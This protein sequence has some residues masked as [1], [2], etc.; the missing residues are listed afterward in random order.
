MAESKVLPALLNEPYVL[1]RIIGVEGD[2][3]DISIEHSGFKSKEAA[4]D[5][6][7][8]VVED[9]EEA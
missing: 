7:K 2:D 4:F 3:V 9:T 6:L 8:L 1:V 5:F